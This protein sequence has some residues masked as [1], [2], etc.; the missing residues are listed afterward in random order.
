MIF[1]EQGI[2]ALQLGMMLFL[3]SAG[4]TLVFGIMN[5]INLAHG[6]L[7]MLGAFAG[8]SVLARTGSFAAA[9]LA[10]VAGAAIGAAVLELAV[11]RRLYARDHSAQ[12]LGTFGLI[13]FFNEAVRMLWG[14]APLFISMPDSLSGAVELL[15]GFRYPAYRLVVTLIGLT[16]AAGMAL[17]I[18]RTRLGALVRAGASN[19][20]MLQ[21]MGVNVRVLFAFV[22]ALGGAL[23]GLAGTLMGPVQSVQVGMGEPVLILAFVV[24]VIGGIGSIKGA[25]VG[26]V[27]VGLV[28]TL[29]RFALPKLFGYTAGPA[30]ASLAIYLL[31]AVMLYFRPN[32]LFPAQVASAG[33]GQS[34][35]E[36]PPRYGMPGR[37]W[38]VAGLAA[39]CLLAVAPLIGDSYQIR[40]LN[41]AVIMGIAALALGLVFGYGGMI[42]FGHSAFVGVGAYAVG[43]LAAHGVSDGLVALPVAVAAAGLAG[44]V[45]GALALRTSG[46]FF[47]MI[48]LAFAQMLYYIAIGLERY[49]GDNGMPLKASTR[50]GTLLDLSSPVHL[51]YTGLAALVTVYLLGRVLVASEFGLALRGIRDNERRMRNL[52]YPTYRYKV[53]AFALSG[54]LCGLAG[55]LLVNVDSYVGPSNLHWFMSGLLMIMVIL[56]GQ[57]SLLGPV[58]GAMLYVVVEE[59]LSN[60][61]EHWMV[62]FGPLLVLTV[63]LARHGLLGFTLP[64]KAARG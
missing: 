64:A 28:D 8:A 4:L 13:L 50:L 31:M 2:N 47:I 45:I 17:L 37:A 63:L 57:G 52:G 27:L 23:A 42:S 49:G 61:T 33:G 11:L 15:P 19:R 12:V 32:G 36:P 39:L 6:S 5:F 30:L 46:I 51:Y 44:L 34:P 10:G 35:E 48:T 7:Y 26:A 25:F 53:L 14:N 58:V 59:G 43:I 38:L 60:I 3:T 29:G 55:A 21:V 54:A 62:I 56:G 16:V 22:F 41:R 9:L 1:L 40:V 24:I 18:T 20:E